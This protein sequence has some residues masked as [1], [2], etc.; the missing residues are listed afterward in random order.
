MSNRRRSSINRGRSEISACSQQAQKAP[1]NLR[2]TLRKPQEAPES[3]RKPQ[4]ATGDP[5]K[6]A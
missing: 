6:G 2:E 1:E 4:K 5:K 3:S